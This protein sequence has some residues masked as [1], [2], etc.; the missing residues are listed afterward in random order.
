MISMGARG[1]VWS[2]GKIK[3]IVSAPDK[4]KPLSTIGAGD[5]TVAGYMAARAKGE[6]TENALRLATTFGSSACYTEGTRPPMPDCVAELY[7][8]SSVKFV[9]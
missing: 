6:S 7:P 5:S 1:S 4:G 8:M 3:A 2:N 9:D